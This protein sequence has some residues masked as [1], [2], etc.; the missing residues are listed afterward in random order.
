MKFWKPDIRWTPDTL[1]VCLDSADQLMKESI[2]AGF[3]CLDDPNINGTGAPDF[4]M[5]NQDQYDTLPKYVGHMG[6]M[7][8]DWTDRADLDFV[9][10]NPIDLPYYDPLDVSPN[11]PNGYIALKERLNSSEIVPFTT[12]LIF[13]L[14]IY[15]FNVFI[16][17]IPSIAQEIADAR[18]GINLGSFANTYT[19]NL[20]YK[21]AQIGKYRIP[22][23][24]T[25]AR[26]VVSAPSGY[27]GAKAYDSSGRTDAALKLDREDLEKQYS[28]AQE[29]LA[30]AK[31]NLE[32]K[33]A[34]NKI[35]SIKTSMLADDISNEISEY[36]KLSYAQRQDLNGD[37][38]SSIK[39]S[40][41]TQIEQYQGIADNYSAGKLTIDGMNAAVKDMRSNLVHESASSLLE[42]Y[43]M[44]NN[45]DL[46]NVVR[47]QLASTL[48][49][50]SGFNRD[51]GS[52]LAS[53]QNTGNQSGSNP[54]ITSFQGNAIARTE[55][56]VAAQE[57]ET[58]RGIQV[59]ADQKRL[60]NLH[61]TISGLEH[62]QQPLT[63]EQTQQLNEA[64]NNFAKLQKDIFAKEQYKV[65]VEDNNVAGKKLSLSEAEKQHQV[66]IDKITTSNAAEKRKTEQKQ[67]QIALQQA[68]LKQHI[69]HKNQEL[70]LASSADKDRIRAEL[71]H[72]RTQHDNLND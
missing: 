54:E 3:K 56:Q 51:L 29:Q 55:R 38:R 52:S 65:S 46:V 45:A 58:A 27:L 57:F 21:G 17:T 59:N 32:L 34:Q 70:R 10:R 49:S 64:R 30:H 66:E 16:K 28:K 33:A 40:R 63:F 53:I 19:N 22:G 72:L 60:H 47:A 36:K 1:N 2:I 68:N 24:L 37:L 5:G 11:S 23:V 6:Y 31:Y 48:M 43:K 25:A 12:A 42:K 15:T 67:A 18:F 14:V 35:H 71:E 39:Q 4:Y 26:A 9:Y 41:A 50:D 13:I 7:Y 20:L 69:Y 62:S 8:L 61:D 44:E